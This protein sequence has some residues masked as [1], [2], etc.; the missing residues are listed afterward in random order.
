MNRYLI[1]LSYVGTHFRG[2]QKNLIRENGRLEDPQSVEGALE[3]ALKKFRPV[4]EFKIKLSSR[5][6]QKYSQQL[7]TD[8]GVH[9]LNNAVHVDLERHNGK[10]YE[11]D[12]VTQGLNRTFGSQ[13]I[14]IRVLRTRHVPLSFH[15]RLCAKSRTYLYRV[16]VLRPE[17]CDD[18]E[19]IHPF[20]RFIPID[21]HD[22]CYFIA[23]KNFDP[24]RLKRAAALCEGYHDFRTFMAIA[25][26]NQWQQMPTYT[27]RRIERITVERG[28]SM[29]SAFSRELADRYYEYW[30]I[31]IKARSFLYNQVRRMVGA[32]IAAAEARITERDVQQM[33]T[34]PAKSS[35]CDQAVVAP[36]YA[37]FLCQVEH[38][39]ADFEFRHDE[40]PR[41]AAEESPLAAAN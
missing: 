11:P 24:D 13:K 5:F 7:S 8:A 38:D 40:L 41:A 25:R 35:W 37:L 15:A 2:I 20:T 14:P 9:A 3:I 27:L 30:D 36:A 6:I 28:S 32:W 21:E 26:G 4:N 39:P 31:R 23:N 22:R 33:L 17:F 29:A 12:K 19:Q 16:G 18:P 1:N 10:P 34:V